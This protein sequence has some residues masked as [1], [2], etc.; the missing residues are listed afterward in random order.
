MRE[1]R[2]LAPPIMMDIPSNSEETFNQMA[3]EFLPKLDSGDAEVSI[4]LTINLGNFESVKY[5]ISLAETYTGYK[6]DN[7][8]N[9]MEDLHLDVSKRL[10]ANAPNI[11]KDCRKLLNHIHEELSSDK[12]EEVASQ[13]RRFKI[14]RPNDE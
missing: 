6:E 10:A 7:R 2:D 8:N 1:P 5:S 3:D 13:V 11:V 14:N 4:S 12:V 9:K